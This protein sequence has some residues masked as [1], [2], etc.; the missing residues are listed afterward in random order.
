MLSNYYDWIKAFHIISVIFWMAGMLY[1]PRLYVYH[2][3]VPFGSE[4]DKMLQIMEYRLL[5]FIINPTM[6]LTLVLGTI[7]TII[8]GLKAVGIWFHIKITAI[9]ILLLIHGFLAKARKDFALGI[10]R[11]STLFYRVINEVP[12]VLAII[13]VIMVVIKP[14]E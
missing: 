13:A 2:S 11:R 9:L 14:F 7:L 12:A 10:N 4:R 6:I 3:Q 8:Y 5:K 1:L